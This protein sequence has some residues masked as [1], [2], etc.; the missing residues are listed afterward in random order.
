[1]SGKRKSLHGSKEA[2]LREKIEKA[3]NERAVGLS[4]QKLRS[5]LFED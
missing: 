5:N 3:M 2:E 4:F 1:M